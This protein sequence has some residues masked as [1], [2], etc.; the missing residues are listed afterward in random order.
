VIALSVAVAAWAL[1]ACVFTLVALVAL[2]QF[3]APAAA[4]PEWPAIDIVRPCEGLD[5][6]LAEN[7]LA[8]VSAR[9]DGSRRV[10]ICV[11]S[12]ADPAYAVAEQ[13][14][15]RAAAE[16]PAVAVTVVVTGIVSE[17]NRKAAQLAVAEA[18]LDAPVL[19]VADSDVRFDDR[20]LP[21][22][23]GALVA[24][25]RAGAASAPPM[26]AMPSTL[27]DRASAA[28][29]SSTPNA[30]LALAALSARW[31]GHPL[32]AGALVACRREVLAAA[33][34]FAALEP[35]LGEDFELARRLH[36]A[37]RTLATS[38]AP[39][40]FT[41]RGR[42]LYQVV[43]RY[44]RWAMVVRRQRPSLFVTYWLLLGCTPLL[45]AGTLGLGAARAPAWDAALA[46][47]AGLVGARAWLARRLRGRYGLDDGWLRSLGAALV[48]ELLILASSVR[49]LGRAEVV[50]RG[51]RFQVRRGGTLELIR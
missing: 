10:C 23:V 26:D 22:L 49:S 4:P 30:L 5:E 17:A 51:R 32:L 34:G 48:G 24:D 46:A 11:P 47:T 42:S 8:S 31:R 7:L 16:A 29:L 19:I 6:G 50:W 35:Y 28:L 41:D 13:V 25:P 44:A 21:S 39:A 40:R 38:P 2:R 9:Y 15:V 45:V 36:A 1:I 12:A 3:A 33:G 27:G 43:R 18:R 37:G 14:R 20:T